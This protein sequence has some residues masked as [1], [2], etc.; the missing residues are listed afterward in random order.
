MTPT[1]KDMNFT[2]LK[3]ESYLVYITVNSV[4]SFGFPEVKRKTFEKWSNIG[5]FFPASGPPCNERLRTINF[6]GIQ[7]P[8][9]SFVKKE[10]SDTDL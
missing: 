2:V 7:I 6:K 8:F 1:P 4:C 10:E 9:P 5:N 3:V